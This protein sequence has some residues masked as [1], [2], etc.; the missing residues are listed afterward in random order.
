MVSRLVLW[1]ESVMCLLLLDTKRLCAVAY[2]AETPGVKS[3]FGLNKKFS[4]FDW[5]VVRQQHAA[6]ANPDIPGVL[7]NYGDQEFRSD[8]GQATHVVVF[9]DPEALVAE[10]LDE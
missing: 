2:H 3:V 9:G 1:F 10:L 8:P 7:A 5:C 6:G 4:H